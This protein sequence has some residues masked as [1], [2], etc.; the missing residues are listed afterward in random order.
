MKTS[1]FDVYENVKRIAARMRG[2]KRLSA[3]RE[4]EVR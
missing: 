3:E 2:E 4:R 1:F